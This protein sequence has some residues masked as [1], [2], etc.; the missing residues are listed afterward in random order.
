[1][2]SLRKQRGRTYDTIQVIAAFS[3]C[4]TVQRCHL[5]LQFEIAKL[6]EASDTLTRGSGGMAIVGPVISVALFGLRVM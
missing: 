4:R 5:L 1:M 3:R 2:G 6:K